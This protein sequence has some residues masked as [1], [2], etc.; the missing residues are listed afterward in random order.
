MNLELRHLRYFI[1]VAEELHFGRAA[2]RLNISQPPLSQQIRQL[3]ESV[4][5][6][7]FA[8]NNRKVEL[9]SAGKQ[10]LNDARAIL[11]QVKQASER[12]SRLHYGDSG[13]LRLG[14]TSSA[15]LIKRIS[16]VVYQYRLAYPDVHLHMQEMNSRQLLVPLQEGRL[17]LA[18]MRNTELP[19]D[20]QYCLLQKEAMYA[21]VHCDHP[22]AGLRK[23]SVTDLRDEPFVFFDHQGGTALYGEI[24]GLLLRYQIT[25]NITLEVEDAMAILGL[26]ATG[27]GVSI[28]P[29][30]FRRARLNEIVWLELSE[31]DA[32]SE[33]WLVWSAQRQISA[34]LRHMLELMSSVN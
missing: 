11:A 4:D 17:D 25:P 5:A 31:P 32:R 26:V 16:E 21:V 10:F 22:L 34:P 13:E 20:M 15:P 30:S 27:L 14:F 12:A 3:E 18:I 6:R 2:S 28:L 24:L 29:A 33:V 7:L 9:T 23:I 1:A 19:D 8:R